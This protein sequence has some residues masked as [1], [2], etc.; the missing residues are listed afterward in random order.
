MRR[1]AEGETTLHD[2][3]TPAIVAEEGVRGARLAGPQPAASSFGLDSGARTIGAAYGGV[4]FRSLDRQ[5]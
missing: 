2:V 4:T 1:N 3:V 5:S